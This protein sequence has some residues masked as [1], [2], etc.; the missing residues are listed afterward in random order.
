MTLKTKVAGSF[1]ILLLLYGAA[2][3]YTLVRHRDASLRLALVN[4]VLLPLSSE[5]A[6]LQ[7]ALGSLREDLR[8]F[9][10][11][12]DLSP[13]M[14]GISREIRD[15]QPYE[16][17]KRISKIQQLLSKEG[18][19][20]DPMRSQLHLSLDNALQKFEGLQRHTE[21][22]AFENGYAELTAAFGDF[23]NTLNQEC[24]RIAF[25]AQRDSQD[26]LL[27]G[28]LLAAFLGMVGL[29][30]VLLSQ[31]AL[32][33][34]PQLL[35]SIKRIADGDFNTRL[36]VSPSAN[37]EFSRLAREYNRALGALEERDRKIQSQQG[38]LLRTERLAAVGQLSAEVVH[39]IRNP[40]NAISLNI[41][42]LE[43]E[44]Q[45][46]DTEISNTLR[47]ISREIERLHQITESYLV[48]AR[49]PFREQKSCPVN[50]VIKEVVE[51]CREED[52]Q[53]SISTSL[54]L[55]EDE[56][57]LRTDRTRLKQALLNVLRNAREA[58]PQGGRISISS[59]LQN[60]LFR[61]QIR[62][63]GS[64]MSPTVRMNATQPFFTT[65]QNGTGIGLA[66][67]RTIVEDAHGNLLCE[68]RLGEGTT[69]TF[70]FPV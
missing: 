69:V 49:T 27:T 46:T 64:G 26:A 61:L 57:Y 51:F 30:S 40:L 2:S 47:S 18:G 60:N 25:N 41:D 4:G 29:I 43:N 65:K 70:Q 20:P 39:E 54:E 6:G 68:S 23:S 44:L 56:F 13:E 21:E 53:R 11:K 34:L 35:Q 24:E 52:K 5:A 3:I 9:Y 63:S 59:G 12:K 33:P 36:K 48:R 7:T 67:T 19:L 22:R 62:D 31:Q 58:M 42:W 28:M 1:L 66:V 15:L 14:S 45:G 17:R 32:H 38:E 37:D 8:R 50:E 10:W 55:S 16:I